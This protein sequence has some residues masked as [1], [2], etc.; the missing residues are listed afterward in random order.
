MPYGENVYDYDPTGLPSA[1]PGFNP[2]VDPNQQVYNPTQDLGV[3]PAAPSS[4][5]GKK[6]KGK[7]KKR[8]KKGAGEQVNLMADPTSPENLPPEDSY[9]GGRGDFADPYALFASRIPLAQER[10]RHEVGGSMA[11]MG[12][13]GNR[14]STDAMKAAARIGGKTAAQ[15][16]QNLYDLLYGSTNMDLDMAMQ[17]AGGGAQLGG[18]VDQL[19]G[20]RI[21]AL[22][23]YGSAVQSHQNRMNS[24]MFN[25][26]NSN[27]MGLLPTLIRAAG[28]SPIDDYYGQR[29][30][31]GPGAADYA[32]DAAQLYFSGADSG[33]W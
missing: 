25:A 21:D 10:M 27:D 29:D 4:S 11:Q 26:M 13:S 7:K 15:L 23:Q 12:A 19:T 18:Q 31:G 14:F 30:A 16:Q 24:A 33:W 20:Q 8:K 17:A 1:E 5:G 9:Y 22:G 28:R 6:K 32:M 3:E 2:N